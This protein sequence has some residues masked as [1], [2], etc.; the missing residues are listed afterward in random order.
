MKATSNKLLWVALTNK[1]K[2]E[3]LIF[4]FILVEIRLVKERE[5]RKERNKKTMRRVVVVGVFLFFSP[6]SEEQFCL[7]WFLLFWSGFGDK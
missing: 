7:V 5:R 3:V 1:R 4:C 6:A 2:V